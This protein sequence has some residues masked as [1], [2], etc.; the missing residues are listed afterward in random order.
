MFI[1]LFKI[2]IYMD[3]PIYLSFFGWYHHLSPVFSAG[4]WFDSANHASA[5]INL[6]YDKYAYGSYAQLCSCKEGDLGVCFSDLIHVMMGP[7][8]VSP[9]I[10]KRLRR[11][12]YWPLNLMV[13]HQL[14]AVEL[15]GEFMKG[16]ISQGFSYREAL[17]WLE[18]TVMDKPIE[19]WKACYWGQ[20]FW[21]LKFHLRHGPPSWRCRCFMP[22]D[23]AS[24]VDYARS[25][26][27]A[28]ARLPMVKHHNIYDNHVI[29]GVID[30]ASQC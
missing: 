17:R 30:D 11:D 25:L 20:G 2:C 8:R 5:G 1:C 29:T 28:L 14:L 6:L 10:P 16:W 19:V 22:I 21:A 26:L 4:S 18:N 12:L 24:D 15:P 3:I 23:M 7:S 27:T 13:N 9:S